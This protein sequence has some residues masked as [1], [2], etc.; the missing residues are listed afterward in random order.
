M[1]ELGAAKA[2]AEV[3]EARLREVKAAIQGELLEATPEERRPLKAFEV[4]AHPQGAYDAW[5]MSWVE[6]WRLDSK[7]MKAEDPAA[8]VKYAVKNGHYELRRHCR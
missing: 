1:T 3:A 5:A 7:R 8:Y 2:A 6:Q 4:R